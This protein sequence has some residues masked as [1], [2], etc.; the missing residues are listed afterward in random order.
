MRIH[1]RHLL[2][3]MLYSISKNCYSQQNDSLFNKTRLINEKVS[4]EAEYKLIFVK[5][6]LAKN[7][8]ILNNSPKSKYD[9]SGKKI[10]FLFDVPAFHKK[11][12]FKFTGGL[13]TYN[14][15][16]RSFIDTP[17]A[18]TNVSQHYAIG[19]ATFQVASLFPVRV[20]YL[21]RY[22]NSKYFKNINNVQVLFDGGNYR[23]SLNETIHQKLLAKTPQFSDSLTEL[24]YILKQKE[25][26]GIEGWI[27]NPFQKQ[28]L[29]EAQ[30]IIQI[31]GIAKDYNLPDSISDARVDSMVISAKKFMA[32][33][34]DKKNEY[35]SLKGQL[36]S[37][38]KTM[39]ECKIKYNSN[40]LCD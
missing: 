6:E 25:L 4:G 8:K 26:E 32:F 22:S 20:N 21:V 9:S 14:Y 35:D 2:V 27:K 3:L 39:I 10:S 16:Y 11:T 38:K 28:K 37:L 23:N 36:D 29:V 31:P 33:Y 24:A 5:G 30:E 34:S 19:S 7:S 13:I 18:G 12:L 15:N 40:L 1:L 17:F